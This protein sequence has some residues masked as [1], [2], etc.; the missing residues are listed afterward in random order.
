MN[1]VAERYL[2]AISEQDWPSAGECLSEDVTRVGPLG[3]NDVYTGR[4]PYLAYL[5]KVMPTLIDYRMEIERVV[6]D[7]DGR[8]VMVELSELMT[9]Q[10]KSV[11]T[12]E[13]LVFDL[14]TEGLIRRIGI[15]IQAQ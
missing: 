13:C 10:D 6:T 9:I 7:E 11:R 1:T 14:D 15:Y 2:K 4:E 12:P 3:A 5:S 8:M